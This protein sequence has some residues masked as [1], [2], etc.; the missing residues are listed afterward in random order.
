MDAVKADYHEKRNSLDIMTDA[1]VENWIEV[2]RRFNDDVHRIRDVDNI[3]GYNA[4]YECF[5]EKDNPVY[6]LVNEDEK[7]FRMRRKNFLNKIGR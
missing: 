5:D 7:L 3:Q 4:L 1:K 2:C 6:Y